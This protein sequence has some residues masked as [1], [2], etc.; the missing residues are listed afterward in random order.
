MAEHPNIKIVR[1]KIPILV[2]APHAAPLLRK[3][4]EDGVY[5][6]YYEKKLD[7]VIEQLCDKTNA[8]GIFTVSPNQ[9]MLS[10]WEKEIY[11]EYKRF[12]KKIINNN[13]IQLFVDLH[14]SR[15]DRPFLIDYD[16]IFHERH[17]HDH[18]L[19]NIIHETFTHHFSKQNLSNGFFRP[20]NGRGHRTLT[21][22]VR[23]HLGVQAV[24]LETNSKLRTNPTNLEL[25]VEAVN[26]FVKKYESTITRVQ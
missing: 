10:N 2:S 23:K 5:K 8:W 20:I 11:K 3:S 17:P 26:K 13:N 9:K 25:L 21:Y 19:E 12:V 4:K 6:R 18:H 14:G 1:G 7:E 15:E 16:F 24:Q 22:Y